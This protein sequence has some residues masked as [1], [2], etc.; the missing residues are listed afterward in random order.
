MVYNLAVR[1]VNHALRDGLNLL[2]DYGLKEGS[3]N[4]PVLVAPGPVVTEYERPTER[5]LFHYAR[6]ANPFFH[7]ME[8]LWMLAGRNDVAF[9]ARYAARMKDYSDNGTTL[10]GA[11]GYRWRVNFGGDQLAVIIDLLQRDPQ[12]RRCVL[13]MW[14]T[15]DDLLYQASRDICCNTHCYV[16]VRGG[17]LNMTICCRSNDMLW[18]AHGANAVHF[19]VLQEFLAGAVGVPVG[20]LY[21]LSNNY[22]LY[23]D[24]INPATDKGA[25]LTGWADD[26]YSA[27][28]VIP[29]PLGVTPRNW[30]DWLA[31]LEAFCNAVHTGSGLAG[32]KSPFLRDVA[33]PIAAAHAAFK[34]KRF[35]D[36]MYL[37]KSIAATDWQAA[38]VE[39]LYRREPQEEQ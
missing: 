1:N 17:R 11:Y 10:N 7:F 19:S 24:V 26:R 13:Q 9:V 32:Q 30:R 39:W 22:H 8:A 2:R 37:A 34:N 4:G 16:D 35:D 25:L 3:R 29:Y 5:V 20:T 14:S 15:N 33:A 28:R 12:T 6:D 36:A 21:Q 23:T 38:C 31:D 27:G 18:G